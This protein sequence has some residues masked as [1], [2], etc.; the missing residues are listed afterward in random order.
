VI[1]TLYVCLVEHSLKRKRLLV[2]RLKKLQRV[3]WR[4]WLTLC[5]I[6]HANAVIMP[7]KLEVSC[8]PVED[9][10]SPLPDFEIADYARSLSRAKTLLHIPP[11]SH[12]TISILLKR[13]LPTVAILSA[14]CPPVPAH[15]PVWPLY[16]SASATCC[17]GPTRFTV[18][19]QD[20]EF[21]WRNTWETT[22]ES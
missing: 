13:N 15:S 18:A 20:R 7:E 8:R 9:L 11:R 2:L 4:G 12:F 5:S 21:L 17:H 3:P 19:K 10:V 22:G 14:H 6:A 1:C 16:L